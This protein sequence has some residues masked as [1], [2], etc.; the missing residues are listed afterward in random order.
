M[1]ERY[2]AYALAPNVRSAQCTVRARCAAPCVSANAN[3]GPQMASLPKL[4]Y[5]LA[6]AHGKFY[7]GTST[8]VQ[9]RV[10]AH[11]AGRGAAWTA[12]HAPLS[13]VETRPVT[14]DFDEDVV[15]KEYMRLHGIDAVRGGSY[16]E[17][18]LPSALRV[19]LTREL[20]TANGACFVC[21]AT[22][23]W[24]SQCPKRGAPD[25]DD[26]HAAHACTPPWAFTL[27]LFLNVAVA[28]L[29]CACRFRSADI[30]RGTRRAPRERV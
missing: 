17:V 19:A 23:H 8:N 10:N 13:L 22:D 25:A 29:L 24:A 4:I 28:L 21:G 11:F 18:T 2:V 7:V 14:S 30:V 6:L 12:E 27:L 15:T 16:V 5:V 1:D 9:R 26:A 3:L 20:R